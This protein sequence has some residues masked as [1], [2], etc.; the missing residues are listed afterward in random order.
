MGVTLGIIDGPV[1]VF[2]IA[3]DVN[4]PLV[5]TAAQSAE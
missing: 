5:I 1:R 3:D 4:P 2:V